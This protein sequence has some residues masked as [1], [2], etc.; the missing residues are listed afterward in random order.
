[1]HVVPLWA[2]PLLP[3]L[4]MEQFDILQLQYRYIEHMHEEVWLGNNNFDKMT[5]VRT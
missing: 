4:L 2:D 5:A 3:Q 1:M